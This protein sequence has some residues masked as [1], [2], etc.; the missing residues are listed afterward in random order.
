LD[1]VDELRQLAVG[2]DLLPGEVGNHF[3]VGHGQHHVAVATVLE[4]AH[5][6]TDLIVPARFPP[7]IGG[8]NDRHQHFLAADGVDFFPDDLLD[9]TH[10]APA[11]GQQAE[12]TGAEGPNHGGAEHQAMAGQ[13]DIA[14][15]IAQRPAKE[16]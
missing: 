11:Q 8:V 16:M 7:D 13:F 12:D 1:V 5:F 3:L 6:G 10:G 4:P 2:I 14:R 9:L 15:G